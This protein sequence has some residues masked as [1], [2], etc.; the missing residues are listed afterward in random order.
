MNQT[1]GFISNSFIR[2]CSSK[3]SI[4][5]KEFDILCAFRDFMMKEFD[6]SEGT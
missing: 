6:T 2:F 4:E 5:P 3:K 1:T